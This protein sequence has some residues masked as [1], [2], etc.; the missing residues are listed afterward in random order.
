[1]AGKDVPPQ[2][3]A[4]EARTWR[5][6]RQAALRLPARVGAAFACSASHRAGETVRRQGRRALEAR[7][8]VAA[9]GREQ[10]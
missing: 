10:L 6:R 8:D 9:S 3:A 4:S 1:M 2:D 5:L 7:A